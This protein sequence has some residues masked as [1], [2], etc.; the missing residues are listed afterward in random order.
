M[1]SKHRIVENNQSVT[2]VYNTS[3]NV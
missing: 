3:L 2:Y 1:L